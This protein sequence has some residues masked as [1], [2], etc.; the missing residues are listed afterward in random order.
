ML[1]L[2]LARG[3]SLWTSFSWVCI[4]LA[5]GTVLSVTSLVRPD[6]D[7]ATKPAE[8]RGAARVPLRATGTFVG[9]AERGSCDGGGGG[10][11]P[12]PR[13]SDVDSACERFTRSEAP[14]PHSLRLGAVFVR[15]SR[16]RVLLLILLGI[17][18]Y[19]SRSVGFSLQRA[20]SSIDL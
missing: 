7:L 2:S 12:A 17:V 14:E 6:H 15:A 11:V 10:G 8:H 1:F 13:Q 3:S 5:D 4:L 16:R 18:S 19:C 20:C 9:G